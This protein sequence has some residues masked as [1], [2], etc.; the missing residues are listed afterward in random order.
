MAPRTTGFSGRR[1]EQGR[2]RPALGSWWAGKELPGGALGVLRRAGPASSPE[3]PVL[4]PTSSPAPGPEAAMR[5]W[6]TSVR[7]A[8]F[9]G[10]RNP[11]GHAAS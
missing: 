1:G 6:G 4:S 8:G 3:H 5:A 7:G 2:G 10:P 11:R 9:A